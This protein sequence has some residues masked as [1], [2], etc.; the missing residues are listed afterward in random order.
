MRHRRILCGPGRP[1]SELTSFAPPLQNE[2]T[3][4]AKGPEDPR[5]STPRDIEACRSRPSSQLSPLRRV[6]RKS[7]NQWRPARDVYRFAPLRPRWSSVG[8]VYPLQGR[9]SPPFQPL[10]LGL[11]STDKDAL[12]LPAVRGPR[13]A[14]VRPGPMRLGPPVEET[15]SHLQRPRPATASRLSIWS[16]DQ[17]PSVE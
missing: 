16:A 14:R 9:D 15:A 10:A 4:N 3:R 13:R 11:A 2:G 1:S 12:G 5:A 6:N 8:H 7:P 17:T